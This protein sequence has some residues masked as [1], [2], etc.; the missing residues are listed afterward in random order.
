MK[1]GPTKTRRSFNI[2]RELRFTWMILHMFDT[3]KIAN[4]MY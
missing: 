1:N 4:G 3:K 2:S